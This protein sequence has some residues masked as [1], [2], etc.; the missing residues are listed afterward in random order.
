[1]KCKFVFFYGTLSVAVSMYS[2]VFGAGIPNE[3]KAFRD[4][5]ISNSMEVCVSVEEL[6]AKYEIL[7]TDETPYTVTYKMA[8][9]P[10]KEVYATV[11]Y[12]VTQ[13]PL[14]D[15]Y[16]E[17]G[18][19][20]SI[21]HRKEYKEWMDKVEEK[22]KRIPN[23]F[24]ESVLCVEEK[25]GKQTKYGFTKNGALLF[26]L[27]HFDNLTQA[28]SIRF[29]F[30]AKN[31]MS[32]FLKVQNGSATGLSYDFDKDGNIT[33]T[34]DHGPPQAEQRS[35]TNWTEYTI[36]LK[37]DPAEWNAFLG[38]MIDSPDGIAFLKSPE[39]IE[40]L[41]APEGKEFMNS[42][43]GK[44]FIKSTKG[45]KYRESPEGKTFFATPLAKEL[46]KNG[47]LD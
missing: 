28:V 21:N 18:E 9:F 25:A 42:P 43:E 37:I 19:E 8:D 20:P 47:L 15:I 30:D 3:V 41:N 36:P 17:V 44:A 29:H 14:C 31:Q 4:M 1:M 23:P 38:A 10:K 26:Y 40:F 12:S 32:Q 5:V 11:V 34:F 16:K 33:Q 6:K 46:I 39:G 2:S 24:P 22:M 27:A 13:R 7:E 35:S 45:K